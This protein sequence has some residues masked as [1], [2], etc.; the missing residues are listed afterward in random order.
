MSVDAKLAEQMLVSCGRRCCIC[1][2]FEPL[3]LQVHHIRPRSAGG[4]DSL[5][6]L[7][8]VCLTCHSD[9]HTQTQLTRRFT[10]D[11]LKGH[12]DSLVRLVGE[13]KLTE[14]QRH[15]IDDIAHSVLLALG[16]VVPEV[17]AEEVV[18]APSEAIDLLV[19]CVEGDGLIWDT[20]DHLTMGGSVEDARK[21]AKFKHALDWLES[22]DLAAYVS[23][24]VYRITHEG[25]LL[26]DKVIAAA[27]D[28]V[29]DAGTGNG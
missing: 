7:I 13:G 26:A 14:G 5:D 18:T 20:S 16:A 27:A 15:P 10:E 17:S 22:N 29:G 4:E 24:V 9:I 2:R 23:G 12:R 11:E 25:F 8:V 21:T 6:N 1:R 19:R 3:H 28:S